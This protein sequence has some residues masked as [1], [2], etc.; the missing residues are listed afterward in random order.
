MI[1]HDIELL[2]GG[3]DSI[4]LI[5]RFKDLKYAKQTKDLLNNQNPNLNT[6]YRIKTKMVI[7]TKGVST[8]TRQVKL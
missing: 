4:I 8:H 5:A 3:E 6:Y 2:T 7:E 1:Y